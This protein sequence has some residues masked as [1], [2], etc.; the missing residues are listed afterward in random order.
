MDGGFLDT[1]RNSR[2]RLDEYKGMLV[3]RLKIGH[4]FE[5]RVPLI[6][7]S[8]QVLQVERLHNQFGLSGP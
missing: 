3:N 4:K 2:D 7:A 5:G 1:P 6:G 8:G